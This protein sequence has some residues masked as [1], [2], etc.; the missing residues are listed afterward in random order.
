MSGPTLYIVLVAFGV[1]VGVASGLLGVGGG[2][3]IESK[4]GAM[5]PSPS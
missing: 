4:N 5:S 2:T 1:V 3:L